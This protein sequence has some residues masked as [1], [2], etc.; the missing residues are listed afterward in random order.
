MCT[1]THATTG[2]TSSNI[3]P[4]EHPWLAQTG[5]H[6]DKACPRRHSMHG[7]KHT[8]RKPPFASPH[9]QPTP[10]QELAHCGSWRAKQ[11]RHLI[12]QTETHTRPT[13]TQ[14][15]TQDRTHAPQTPNAN[16]R[17]KPQLKPQTVTNARCCHEPQNTREAASAEPGLQRLQGEVCV[18]VDTWCCSTR[19]SLL[20]KH[21]QPGLEI[22]QRLWLVHS[23]QIHAEG[24]C[25][26]DTAAKYTRCNGSCSRRCCRR[27]SGAS[28]TCQEAL[29]QGQ[30][31]Q[32]RRCCQHQR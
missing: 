23:A 29:T 10:P 20:Q 19:P 21:R 15:D 6:S 2:N 9:P 5:C 30:A 32:Q 18:D 28:L 22:T 8:Q 17:I 13:H 11:T 31:T 4:S 27:L 14:K 16:H 12:P 24:M 25:C 1:H 26:V 3:P 7:N